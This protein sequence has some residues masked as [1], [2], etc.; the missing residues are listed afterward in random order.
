MDKNLNQNGHKNLDR[1][2]F[3][4]MKFYAYHGVFPEENKLGQAYF[5]DIEVYLDLKKAGQTDALEDTV[6]YAQLFE[7]TK[8][9]VEG[10][11]FKLIE[12]VAKHISM[13]ILDQI[14]SIHE[15]VVK[16]TKP[17]PPIPGHYDAVA[18]EIR[19]GRHDF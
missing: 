7:I 10:R 19:R 5:V 16:V 8:E 14:P 3:Q 18:V 13:T 1:I 4:G 15:T 12:S 11:T 6:N 9:V 17:N 2:L